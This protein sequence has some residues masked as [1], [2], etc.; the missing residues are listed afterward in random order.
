MNAAKT[1]PKRIVPGRYGYSPAA[2]LYFTVRRF[3]VSSVPLWC[4][5]PVTWKTERWLVKHVLP[6][7]LGSRTTRTLGAAVELLDDAAR[8]AAA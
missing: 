8:K 4:I 5:S 7:N 3:H 6:L 1:K 2:G